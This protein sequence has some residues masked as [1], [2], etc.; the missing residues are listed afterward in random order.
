MD[1]PPLYSWPPFF[2]L[3]P[4]E[5]TRDQQ[6]EQWARLLVSWCAFHRQALLPVLREWPL[7]RNAAL[8][9]AWW[10]QIAAPE[11]LRRAPR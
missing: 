7:W 9:R 2:T 4:Q 5:A 3:Q 8:D 10:P 6:L 1:L 11:S